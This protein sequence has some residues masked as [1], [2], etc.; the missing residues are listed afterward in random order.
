MIEWTEQQQM[1]RGMMRDFIEKE[2]QPHIDDLEY[3]GMPP[4]D[5]MRK[6]FATFGIDQ[7]ATANFDRQI[8]R[9][10]AGGEAAD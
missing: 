1:I 6:M 10:E 7:M 4:Y 9:E 2:I 8:A 5:L 3:N